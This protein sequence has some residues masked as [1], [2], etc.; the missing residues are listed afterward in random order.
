MS[1]RLS[2]GNNKVLKTASLQEAQTTWLHSDVPT[3]VTVMPWYAR[4]ICHTGV[5][6]VFIP[7]TNQIF[8]QT[9]YSVP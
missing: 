1:V 7:A 4:N 3:T 6:G 9:E 5:T 8:R 2:E